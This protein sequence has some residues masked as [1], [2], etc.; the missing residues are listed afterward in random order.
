VRLVLRESGERRAGAPPAAPTRETAGGARGGALRAALALGP[1]AL[2]GS[3]VRGAGRLLLSALARAARA[4]LARRLASLAL[5]AAGVLALSLRV[6]REVTADTRYRV[7]K[8]SLAATA[9]PKG[10]AAAAVQDLARIA[11]PEG[12]RIGEDDRSFSVYWPEAVPAVVA[13]YRALPWVREVRAVEAFFPARVRFDLVVRRPVA[14]LEHD[15]T[16]FLLDEEGWLLPR[17]CYEPHDPAALGLPLIV[18]ARLGRKRLREG[19]RLEDVPVRHGV[20]VALGLQAPAFDPLRKAPIRIDVSNVNFEVALHR[21][22]VVVTAGS[23]VLEWGRSEASEG[24]NIPLSEKIAHFARVARERPLD[25]L[26]LVR[27]QFD[28]VEWRERP[29]EAP[30]RVE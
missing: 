1:R 27:L 12:A 19:T 5:L 8:A 13:S 20:A 23:T 18:K 4:P 6:E 16:T 25:R 7:S 21:P 30:A 11:A 15:E 10:L 29:L 28:E 2:A 3:I 24:E 26:S 9:P 17:R 22:E 14:G